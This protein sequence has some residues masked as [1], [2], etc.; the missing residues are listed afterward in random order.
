MAY[1]VFE[2]S[3]GRLGTPTMSFSKL[4]QVVFNQPAAK[5]LQKET[6]ETILLLW[7]DSTRTVAM[8]VTSNKK[9]TRA[10]TI[11]FNP[12]GN[13]ASFSAKTFL[14][15]VGIDFT[16]RRSFTI[17]I[18]SNREY[19]VE[20]QVPEAYFKKKETERVALRGL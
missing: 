10:Y 4:G 11:R 20:V 2:R 7:D 8:K 16:T 17:E 12:N 19:F 5:I 9:D 6:I 18:N 15:F 3:G 14:D 13:G 1:E